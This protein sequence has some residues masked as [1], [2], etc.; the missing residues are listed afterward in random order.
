MNHKRVY[1]LYSQEGLAM[2]RRPPRR[3]VSCLKRVAPPPTESLNECWSMDFLSDQLYDGRRLRVLTIVDNHSRE[4]LGIRVGQRMRGREVVEELH[5]IS[6][7]RKLPKVIRVDNGPEFVS[8][9]LDM[10]AYWNS[11]KLDFIRPG[12]P[13][14]NA[15]IEAFHSRFRQE[16]LNEHWFLSLEDAQEKVETWRL[17][18][19]RKR[20]HSSLE[21]MPPA[22]FAARCMAPASATLRPPPY[23][24]AT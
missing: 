11:V 21:N 19:N 24:E 10:W 15:I 3:R 1:R 2:R 22:E 4:S 8:K 7:R 9:D 16:C 17:E 13:T 12:K 18:Y 5:R 20:P 23:T 6:R 14:D